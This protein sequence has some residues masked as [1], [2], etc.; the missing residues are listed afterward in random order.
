MLASRECSHL[1]VR[2]LYSSIPLNSSSFD[3][4]SNSQLSYHS[5]RRRQFSFLVAI[6]QHPEYTRFIRRLSFEF[7]D[8]EG[9]PSDY[10]YPI[11]PDLVWRTFAKCQGVVYFDI[12]ANRR[13]HVDDDP[14]VGLFPNLRRARVSGPFSARTLGQLLNTSHSIH[15]L[16][17][18]ND[19]GP[20][21]SRALL[22]DRAILNRV[23]ERTDP[24]E[25]L[26]GDLPALRTLN[27]EICERMPLW[28]ITEFLQHAKDHVT[29]LI[30]KF[31]PVSIKLSVGADEDE[32]RKRAEWIQNSLIGFTK[33]EELWLKGIKVDETLNKELRKIGSLKS[34]RHLE[35]SND[36][37]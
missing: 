4:S 37:L 13:S 35:T 29:L 22:T 23:S 14:K 5:L 34:I 12:T 31:L 19:C 33:L 20:V 10:S 16:E 24:F 3:P 36:C 15:T 17:I 30:L 32:D 2:A 21:Y 6:S 1:A 26:R 27:I 9:E 28:S 25:C 8:R 11:P 18:S 7:T